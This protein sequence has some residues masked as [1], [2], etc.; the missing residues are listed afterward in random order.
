MII[1]NLVPLKMGTESFGPYHCLRFRWD[2]GPVFNAELAS[3]AAI[4]VVL[5]QAIY[6]LFA[7]FDVNNT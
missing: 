2:G 6:C 4:Q 1:V 7:E 5:P 3:K